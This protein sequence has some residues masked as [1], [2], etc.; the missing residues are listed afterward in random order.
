MLPWILAAF[1]IVP[2]AEIAVFVKI[3][4]QWGLWPTIGAVFATAVAGSILIRHQGVAVFR[5]VQHEMGAGRLPARQIF[6]G[7]CLLIAGALL[8]TP[9][10]ITDSVGF[11]LLVPLARHFLI[12][13]IASRI[14]LP[15]SGISGANPNLDGQAIDGEFTDVTNCPPPPSASDPRLPPSR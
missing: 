13:C 3:G 9:G 10:F 4:G 7:L 15:A 14:Q 2:I 5:Q 6:D 11:L 1:V 12:S 8:L